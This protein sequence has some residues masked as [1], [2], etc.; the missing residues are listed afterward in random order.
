M[1]RVLIALAAVVLLTAAIVLGVR[2]FTKPSGETTT[3][4]TTTPG[5]TTTT[6]TTTPGTGAVTATPEPPAPFFAFRRLEIE[7]TGSEPEACL[8]FTRKLDATGAVKYED[9]LKFDP[10][11]KIAVRATEQ[12]LCIAGLAFGQDYK[13]EIKEGLPAADP[14]DKIS[15]SETIPVELRDKPSLVRFGNGFVLP[16]ENADGV[17]ITTVNVGKLDIKVIR[18]GDRLLSQLQTGVVDQ[19]EFYDYERNNIENE[20]GQV[21]WTGQMNV[22]DNRRNAEAM[23]V[24]PL[25]KALQQKQ[26]GPGVYQHLPLAQPHQRRGAHAAVACVGGGAYG[27]GT[28]D[29]R[30]AHRG[31]CAQ[32]DQLHACVPSVSIVLRYYSMLRGDDRIW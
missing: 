18:V 9:Y 25:R 6:G 11:T 3:A 23:T 8:V 15:K 5:T 27:A 4:T 14:A 13:L 31:A 29:H 28:P 10:D 2:Y 17:P 26:V 19:R 30:H 22:L 21:I 12:R 1:Q 32:E 16:R 7:T 24:F 20:Q